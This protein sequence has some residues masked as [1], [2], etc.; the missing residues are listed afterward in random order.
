MLCVTSDGRKAALDMRCIDPNLPDYAG[1]KVNACIR[2]VFDIY[3][4]TET[5]KSAQM[6][7]CDISTPKNGAAFSVYDD[8]R[9]K[10]ISMGMKPEEIAFIH[11]AKNE[12]QKEAMFAAVRSGVIRVIIGSTQKTG[13]GTNCQKR[14]IALHHLDCPLRPSDLEQRD[15]RIL[16]RGNENPEVRIYQYVTKNCFDSY[17]WQIV[18]SKARSISQV[19]S[20]KN[21]SREVEDM[22]EVVLNYAEVKA[23]ATGNPLIKRKMELEFELQRLQILEAQYI[24]DRYGMENAVLK[25]IP[26][27]LAK[28]AEEIKG[29]ESDIKRRDSHGGDF[30]IRLGKHQF[31]ERKEAGDMLLKAVSSNQYAGKVIGYYRGFE[32][33]P[34]QRKDMFDS[35]VILLKGL[36]THNVELSDSDVGSITRIENRLDRLEGLRDDN[37]R[38]IEDQERRLEATKFQLTCPFEQE[39]ELQAVLSELARINTELDIDHGADDGALLDDTVQEDEENDDVLSLIDED[40]W[41][42]EI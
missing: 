15:G 16:R 33:I 11:D 6:I 17:L 24:A 32:I 14:L 7:F 29:C 30:N 4:E 23:I 13:V 5:Q 38:E 22:S 8:I 2:N 28:L 25:H 36:K 37:L 35:Q 39:Q 41:A 19:M 10:L 12:T 42:D 20:G 34:I 40:E 1:S 31:T 18:E 27:K 21:P 9:D 26:A 3:K